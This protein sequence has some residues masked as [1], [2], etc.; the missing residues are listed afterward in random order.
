MESHGCDFT[1]LTFKLQTK[2]HRDVGDNNCRSYRVKQL[3]IVLR[4]LSQKLLPAAESCDHTGRGRR[5]AWTGRLLRLA[6]INGIDPM[7]ITN[8]DVDIDRR[9]R[10]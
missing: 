4:A 10:Y 9:P 8:V 1:V 6:S 3:Q 5:R 7:Q 2:S